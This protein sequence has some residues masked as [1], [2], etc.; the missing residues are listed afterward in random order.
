MEKVTIKGIPLYPHQKAIVKLVDQ[1]PRGATIVVKSSRQK[2]KSTV[3][4]QLVLRN[5]LEHNGVNPTI[6]EP[7]N[8]SCRRQMKE[9]VRLIANIPIVKSVNFQFMDLELVNDSVIQFR[10][11]EAKD[12]L[13]G[14]SLKNK[15]LLCIDESA[16]VS[17]EVFGIVLPFTNVHSNTK[18]IVSTPKFKAGA[19][20]EHYK[21]A[22]RK[23]NNHFLVD[24]NDY[25]TSMMI[26]AEQLEE[27]KATMA[28]N[29]F[30]NE[31]MG[32]FMTEEGNVFGAFGH[33]ISNNFNLS[34]KTY[35]F[36]IDWSQNGGN[37]NTAISIFNSQKEQVRL[38]YFNDKDAT[39][40]IEEIVKLAKEYKPVKITCESNSMGKTMYQ[41]LTK[42]LGKARVNT[43]V[44]LF[45]TTNESKRRIIESMALLIQQDAVRFLDDVEMKLELAGYECEPTKSGKSI[46]YNGKSGIKD[47]CIIATAICLD[48]MSRATYSVR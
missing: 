31:Y 48:S 29:I 22:K 36:G 47:D 37:D 3:L 32:E 10:S 34:N 18:I 39:Q 35:Y 21:M 15:S 9:L 41:L 12:G 4:N 17:D 38:V 28:Y 14:I 44:S 16:F 20:Y 8:A 13:R 43:M 5:A 30:L 2:G 1:Y 40:T 23:V 19:Y 7:T 11:A 42:E 26:S 45:D 25:D 24:F 6:I 27:A 33:C 46:T